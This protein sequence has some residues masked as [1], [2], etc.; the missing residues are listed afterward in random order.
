MDV[1]DLQISKAGDA[2]TLDVGVAHRIA[3]ERCWGTQLPDFV[4]IRECIVRSRLGDLIDGHDHWWPLDESTAG[5]DAAAAV[6]RYALPFLQSL[7]S[8]A[9]IERT[10]SA[11]REVRNLRAPETIYLA[12]LL[13]LDGDADAGCSLLEKFRSKTRGDWKPRSEELMGTLGCPKPP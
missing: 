7:D 8:I 6:S 4:Q 11:S 10:L 12:I 1:V 3:Y 2:F 5:G 9:A 13:H